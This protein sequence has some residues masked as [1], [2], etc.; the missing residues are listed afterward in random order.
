MNNCTSPHDAHFVE[1]SRCICITAVLSLFDKLCFNTKNT[2]FRR[3]GTIFVHSK[4]AS[5]TD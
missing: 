3:V 4:C 2:F 1:K 5:S